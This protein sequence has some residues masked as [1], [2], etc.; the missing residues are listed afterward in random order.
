M[1]L[2][3]TIKNTGFSKAVCCILALFIAVNTSAQIAQHIKK[4]VGLPKINTKEFVISYAIVIKGDKGNGIAQTYNGGLKTAFVKN[5]LVRLRLVSLMRV[6]SIYFNNKK[7]LTTKV[8]SVVKE[9]G[10]EKALMNLNAKQWKKY[11]NKN[12]SI[13][14]EIFKDDTIRILDHLCNKAIL[15]LKDSS[16]LT[17]Y[18]L[19]ESKS[20]TLAAA[21]PLFASI[22]GLVMKYIFEKG[23]KS[24]EYTATAL[25]FAPIAPSVFVKPSKGYLIQKYNP[26]GASVNTDEL[27]AE[28]EDDNGTE[29]EET[30]METPSTPAGTTPATP[31][32]N[33]P[34]APTSKPPF[35][36]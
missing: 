30:E 11:N 27:N 28:E 36:Q 9:S 16:K 34:P 4:K 6:Q 29:E 3:N 21:E 22:P 15:T 32:T 8:A 17:V 31:A 7:G 25:K 26:G 10:K 23:S 14:C 5:D 35:L 12:D 1:A 24:I 2:K 18:Y 33:T 13:K 20:K 19:P